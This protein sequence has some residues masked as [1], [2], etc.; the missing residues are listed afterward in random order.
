MKFLYS[1]IFLVD[2]IAKTLVLLVGCLSDNYSLVK[3][4]KVVEATIVESIKFMSGKVLRVAIVQ[5]NIFFYFT[6]LIIFIESIYNI[7]M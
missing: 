1:L 7:Y 4:V 6:N 5:V 3:T 2:K